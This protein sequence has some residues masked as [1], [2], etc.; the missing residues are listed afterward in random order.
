MSYL[1]KDS[2]TDVHPVY[3]K[4][5]PRWRYYWASFNG[6]FDYRNDSLG[7]LRR[8]MN[9]GQQPG[10]QYSQRLEYTALETVAK[11]W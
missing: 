3:E 4:H 2:I 9:E 1:T 6:G 5:L 11:W 10:N 8:Y 7:M